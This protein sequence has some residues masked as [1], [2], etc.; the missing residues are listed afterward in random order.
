MG[1]GIGDALRTKFGALLEVY[2]HTIIVHLNFNTPEATSFE[3]RG[4][5]TTEER[6]SRQV[7]FQFPD[8]IDVP[9]GSV[10]QPKGSRDYWKVIDTEDI[11]KDDTFINFEVRVEKINLAG[12][13]TRPTLKGSNTFNLHGPHSRV[14][15]Q[16]QDQSVNISHQTT[17]NLF[18][19]MRQ[20]I[21]THIENEQERTLI[22]NKLDELE[23]AKGTNSF[24]QK[25][26]GFIA[27][28]ANH[29]SILSPFIPALA[30]MLGGSS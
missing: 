8:Q 2:G 27:S 22:L 1:M 16:S 28:A 20:V 15:I 14:N 11:V 21:Q 23:A 10:L 4:R 5:Q 26:Q 24:L 9:V 3:V 7:I 17:E 25:Y 12:E 29:I 6:N 19:D 18:A 30:Q 13:P